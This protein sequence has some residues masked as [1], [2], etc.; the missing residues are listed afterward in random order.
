MVEED[1]Q[2]EPIIMPRT[3]KNKSLDIKTSTLSDDDD[4][5]YN[6][7]TRRKQRHSK[8]DE[9]RHKHDQQTQSSNRKY[10]PHSTTVPCDRTVVSNVFFWAVGDFITVNLVEKS[11][12]RFPL[13]FIFF[14]SSFGKYRFL[15]PF[16][17]PLFSFFSALLPREA[18]MLARSWGS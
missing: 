6:D 8:T 7:V 12:F 13:P 4:D 2:T 3:V 10:M 1:T 5:D 16:Y 11:E 9:H 18:A 17:R 14:I 15:S